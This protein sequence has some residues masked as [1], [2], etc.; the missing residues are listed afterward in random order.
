MWLAAVGDFANDLNDDV[1]VG[2][3]G[4]DVG[5]ADLGIVEVKL[6]D[7]VIDSLRSEELVKATM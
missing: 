4:I 5:D 1:R 2:A 7:A 3:L 6:F